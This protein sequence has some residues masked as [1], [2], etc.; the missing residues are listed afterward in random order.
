MLAVRP[1]T[2]V[3]FEGPYG[4]FTDQARTAPRL[5][6]LA[7]GIGV[8]SVRALLEQS[9]PAPGEATILLR[10]SADGRMFLWDEM[11]ALSSRDG[12]RL[13]VSIGP[14]P[15]KS[16]SWLSAADA[17]RGVSIQTIFPDLRSS[18]LNICGPAEWTELAVAAACD[19]GLPDLQLHIEGFDW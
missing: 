11:Q 18:D 1:G 10:Y 12:A 15:A 3:S 8:T 19:A 9:T 16:A 2:R 6:I 13:Y 7:S 5:A 17:A 14:R 4:L